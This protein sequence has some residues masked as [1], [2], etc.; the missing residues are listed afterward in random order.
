MWARMMP[1]V[2]GVTRASTAAGSKQKVSSISASTGIAT[3]VYHCGRNRYP[4]IGRHD[5][6]L[7]GPDS[8]RRKGH[9]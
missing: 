7:S 2:W 1:A 5:N 8:Q 9:A 4:Q 6:L 3:L